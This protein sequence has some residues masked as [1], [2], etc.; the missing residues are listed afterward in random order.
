MVKTKGRFSGIRIVLG[1]TGGIA[2]YKAVEILRLL[3]N[4]GARVQVI[5]TR[6]AAEF[7]GPLTFH[8]LSDQPVLTDAEP[9]PDPLDHLWVT[10]GREDRQPAADL[11]IVAP[12]TAN[13]LGKYAWGV[14]DDFLTT[15][16]LAVPCPVLI[17]PA[18]NPS[19]LR[20]PAVQDNLKT[21]AERGV[22]IAPPE[23]GPLA[24]SLEGGGG[25]GPGRLA[26]PET[27]VEAASALLV[28]SGDLAGRKVL[29]TAGPTREKWDAIRFLS[30]RSSGK[31]GFA[32]ADVARRRGA[33]VVLV[34]GPAA[35][36][37]PPGV[38][39]VRVE[40]AEEMRRAVLDALSETDV[41]IKAAAVADYRP[42][43]T[44]EDKFKKEDGE[45]TLILERTTDILDEIGG[46]PDRPLMVGFAAE[47][48]NLAANAKAKLEK[49]NLDIIV[50]N[51]VGEDGGAMG[52]DVSAA[53]LIDRTGREFETGRMTKPALAEV[54]L[55]RIRELLGKETGNV[56]SLGGRNR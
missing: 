17:A 14:A 41:L 5:M 39:I 11:V 19:M 53:I 22:T 46:K 55:D 25:E 21:L 45:V 24:S 29:I 34:S 8:T 43:R 9:P 48:E 23:T 52:S 7:V 47:T 18:M 12:A 6:T 4:D 42:R 40:S 31:M 51:A 44:Q 26:A 16:L 54:I 38:D 35:L 15:A 37:A 36:D 56:R 28:R 1:V 33:E 20:H 49:K 10:Q 2:A 30:N 27:I 50:A 13:F 32:L 3:V